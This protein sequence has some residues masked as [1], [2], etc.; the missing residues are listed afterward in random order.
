MSHK[1]LKHTLFHHVIVIKS[2]TD[3]EICIPQIMLLGTPSFRYLD[4]LSICNL[5]SN[6]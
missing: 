3:T 6:F 4:I 5:N 1:I 2:V